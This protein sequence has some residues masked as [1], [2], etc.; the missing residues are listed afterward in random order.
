MAGASGSGDE[1][2]TGR[3]NRAEGRTILWAQVPPDTANFNGP[4]ILVAEVAKTA[5][6]PD[7]YEDL[8]SHVPSNLFHGIVGTG[9]SG[10]GPS[11]PG[12]TPGAAG[13][14]GR[15]GTNEGT[16]LLGL[17][18]GTPDP[19]YAGFGGIGVHGL[20]GSQRSIFAV[21]GVAPGAGLVGQGGRQP[22]VGNTQRAPHAAGVIGIGGGIGEGKDVLPAH[23]LAETG[24]AGVYAQGAEA[25]LT[26]TGG[27]NDDPGA[28]P[29]GPLDPGA[30]VLGRGGV[31]IPPR[32]P[33]A[34]GVIGLAGGAPIPGLSETGNSGVYGAGTTGVFG[35]GPT[36]VRGQSDVGPGVHGVADSGRG[37]MFESAASAQIRL[38]PQDLRDTFPSATNVTATAIPGEREGVVLPKSGQGGDLIALMDDQRRCN[39]WFCVQGEN[40]GPAE[41]AQVL[42]GPA[43]KGIG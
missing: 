21:P 34:A 6:D 26:L 27:T 33:V 14:I 12:G 43:F 35:H 10:G 16:G 13:V 18:G 37:G 23:T 11:N 28:V 19:R 2:E 8:D 32:G 17:G 5:D 38:V 7:D 9:H 20:G 42:L 24:G 1:V 15:G 40:G 29:S 3:T 25:L 31:P 39:L 41:W 22:D 4:A 30:G 36:G